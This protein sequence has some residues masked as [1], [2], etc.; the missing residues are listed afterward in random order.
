M[1]SM[2]S[3]YKWQLLQNLKLD[4]EYFPVSRVILEFNI[5]LV[6][7]CIILHLVLLTFC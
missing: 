7:L 2:P 1:H 3:K 4:G 6:V 5:F